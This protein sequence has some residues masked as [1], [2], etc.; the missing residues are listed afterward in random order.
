VPF[1]GLDRRSYEL[2]TRKIKWEHQSRVSPH[3]NLSPGEA[4]QFTVVSEMVPAKAIC[5]VEVSVIG[6]VVGALGTWSISQW[7]ASDV[8]LP[9]LES[10][11]PQPNS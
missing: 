11:L 7:R 6:K 4:T 9:R 2:K 1:P 8:S 3:T 10:R 5:Y